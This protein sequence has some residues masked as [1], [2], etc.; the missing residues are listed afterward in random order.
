MSTALQEAVPADVLAREQR[1]AAY[2]PAE[3]VARV[4]EAYFTG[5]RAH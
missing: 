2:L 1:L 5:A 3:Q 4:R